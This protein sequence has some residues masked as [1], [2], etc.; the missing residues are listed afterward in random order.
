MK[1]VILTAKS[2]KTKI[3][4]KITKRKLLKKEHYT[5]INNCKYEVNY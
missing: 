1:K 2:I 3:E 4:S 5:I